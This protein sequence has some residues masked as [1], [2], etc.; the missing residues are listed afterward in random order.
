MVNTPPYPKPGFWTDVEENAA[1]AYVGEVHRCSP[2]SVCLGDKEAACET[3]YGGRLC[4]R[5]GWQNGAD[6]STA[7][8]YYTVFG[9]CQPCQRGIEA[10]FRLAAVF[11][12]WFLVNLLVAVRGE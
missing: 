8:Q 11:L 2:P 4:T 3:G 7:A 12:L 9:G 5:C 10:V 1:G 6:T